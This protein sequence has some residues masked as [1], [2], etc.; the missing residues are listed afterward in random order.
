MSHNV[1]ASIFEARLLAWAKALAKPLKVVVENEAYKPANGEIYLQAFTLPAD[2]SSE[3]L[4]GDHRL[5]L[6]VFQVSIV[7]PSGKYRGPADAIA[8]QVTAL[9]P[10]Y[11]RNT[12]DLLTVVTMTPPAQGPGI[13]DDST[14]TVPVSFEY[15]SDTN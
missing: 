7:T 3:T 6:G 15:R 12:K 2:T 10:L 4:A 13:T 8:D 5:Y 14:Y 11:E 1:I 9:F